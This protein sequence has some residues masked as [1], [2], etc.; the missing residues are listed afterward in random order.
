MHN[1]NFQG[2]TV[3]LLFAA[4]L[5]F[6]SAASALYAVAINVEFE[7]GSRRSV[8]TKNECFC[9]IQFIAGKWRVYSDTAALGR[10]CFPELT[11]IEDRSES[12]I[13]GNDQLISGTEIKF[14]LL[15]EN[16][17]GLEK[18][19]FYIIRM[20]LTYSKKKTICIASLVREYSDGKAPANATGSNEIPLDCQLF[21]P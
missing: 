14:P 17:A 12:V 8:K 18:A 6:S 21:S 9:S 16:K 4:S 11:K 1:R 10:F 19:G 2:N 13:G 3:A 5:V 15:I 7:D 20:K